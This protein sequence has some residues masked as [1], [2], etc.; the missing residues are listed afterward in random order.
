METEKTARLLYL[1]RDFVK[2]SKVRKQEAA[3][4]F[5]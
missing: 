3:D 5:A 4:R 1:Y 2:G